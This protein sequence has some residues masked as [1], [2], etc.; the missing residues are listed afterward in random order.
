MTF[1][2]A[3]VAFAAGALAH[4]LKH[5]CPMMPAE[6]RARAD[7]ERRALEALAAIGS[8]ATRVEAA[9][10]AALAKPG[11]DFFRNEF[12]PATG[13][14]LYLRTPHLAVHLGRDGSGWKSREP[15]FAAA[16]GSPVAVACE[17]LFSRFHDAEIGKQTK[18]LEEAL[19]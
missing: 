7:K 16:Q 18:K 8:S 3:L 15:E 11:W 9:L 19:R 14:W 12:H 5:V 1:I 10:L 13:G 2:V 4:R 6:E 17:Q